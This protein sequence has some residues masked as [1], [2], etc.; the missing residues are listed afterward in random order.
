MNFKF[1]IEVN[2]PK[3]FKGWLMRCCARY[4]AKMIANDSVQH[5]QFGGYD[6][7]LQKNYLM[8]DADKYQVIHWI[9]TT[10]GYYCTSAQ[11]MERCGVNPNI[12]P[13]PEGTLMT[14]A[15]S[16][17]KKLAQWIA[18]AKVPWLKL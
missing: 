13:S 12:K 7:A 14:I 1:P 16:P 9:F 17:Q 5:Y 4:T 18:H 15:E 2:A 8:V 6:G 3:G 10:A 11:V